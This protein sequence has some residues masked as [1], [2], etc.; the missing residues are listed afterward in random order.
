MYPLRFVCDRLKVEIYRGRDQTCDED[1]PQGYRSRMRVSFRRNYAQDRYIRRDYFARDELGDLLEIGRGWPLLTD[2][3]P[4]GNLRQ[5]NRDCRRR[6][7]RTRTSHRRSPE[8]RPQCPRSAWRRSDNRGP[9]RRANSRHRLDSRRRRAPMRWRIIPG[10]RWK[11]CVSSALPYRSEEGWSEE[12][13]ETA[14]S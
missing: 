1:N 7:H 3:P 11:E 10:L 14:R 12:W 6:P 2:T 9:V 13:G 5:P 4:A 8:W